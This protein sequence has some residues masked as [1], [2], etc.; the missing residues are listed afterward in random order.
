MEEKPSDKFIC[1]E[2]HGLLT[3]IVGIIPPEE[4]NIAVLI[5]QDAV[6]ADGNSVSISAE[7]LENTCGAIKGRFA[8]DDPLFMVELIPERFKGSR[9]FEMAD[10]AGEHK[11]IRCKTF[12]EVIKKLA[13]KKCRYY[14]YGKEETLSAGYPPAAVRGSFA[15]G[16]NTVDVGVLCGSAPR[17]AEC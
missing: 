2:R 6:I 4:G 12:S 9:F 13:F 1:R 16:D 15:P 17:Y 11:T 8:I 10:T 7:I 14:R 3:V 5:G